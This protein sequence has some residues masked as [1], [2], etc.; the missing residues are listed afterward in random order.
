[1]PVRSGRKVRQPG[2]GCAQSTPARR[3]TR[4]P[5]KGARRTSI[6][7]ANAPY[8]DWLCQYFYPL[9]VPNTKRTSYMRGS[10]TLPEFVPQT[11][12]SRF[13]AMLLELKTECKRNGGSSVFDIRE[14]TK[15]R[16]VQMP[17]KRTPQERGRY[18]PVRSALPL[19]GHS[20]L[21]RLASPMLLSPLFQIGSE[22]QRYPIWRNDFG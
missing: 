4:R 12:V 19:K 1:M 2:M 8:E 21:R 18:G 22:N 9:P 5:L 17:R 13:G 11:P 10:Y 16:R 15:Q 14:K 6:E 3:G 20:P 7:G